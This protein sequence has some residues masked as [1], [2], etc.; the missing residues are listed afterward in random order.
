LCDCALVLKEKN[1]DNYNDFIKNIKNDLWDN[2]K[3]AMLESKKEYSL[4]I[5]TFL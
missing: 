1:I 3:K 5:K 4:F 2:E